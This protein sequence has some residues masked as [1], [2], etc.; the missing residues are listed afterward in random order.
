[1]SLFNPSLP[2]HLLK[3]EE[4][5]L[6]VHLFTSYIETK[7]GRKPIFVTP[8]DLRLVTDLDS[9]NGE[10]LHC[11]VGVDKDGVEILERIYQVGLELHQ[12]ELRALPQTILR[13]IALC[14][15]ND[16]RTIF[17]V[18]DKRMLGIVLQELDSLTHVH[19]I[20]TP[21]QADVLRE[22]ITP[23]ILPGSGELFSLIQSSE[24]N[25]KLK[26]GLILKPIRSGKGEGITFGS[27]LESG[28]WLSRLLMLRSP[29]VNP[30][31][32]PFVVQRRIEQPRFD[33][34]LHEEEEFHYNY[35]VGTYMSIHGKYL[36]LG[37]WRTSPERICAISR[38]GAWICSVVPRASVRI[39]CRL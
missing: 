29:E 37:L 34:A 17:L 32:T 22:G 39:R 33:V 3:G 6:D 7:T 38:G 5:G 20:L 8:S 4:A 31:Q 35:L 19:K 28:E 23:T 15:F 18:H 24:L 10:R 14:C 30:D 12:R 1:M 2:L 27:D 16:L 25:P 11:V 13:E 26:D 36:G 21:A 9:T